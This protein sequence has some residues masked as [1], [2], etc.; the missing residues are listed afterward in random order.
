MQR[1][2]CQPTQP[3]LSSKFVRNARVWTTEPTTRVSFKES[4]W[5]F[6]AS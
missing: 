3:E 4:T 1:L 6:V 2:L 5:F